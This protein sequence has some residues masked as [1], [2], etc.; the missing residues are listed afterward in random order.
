MWTLMA[1][2]SA[3]PICAVAQTPPSAALRAWGYVAH[4][5]P[6]GWRDAPL[7]TFERLLFF[8]AP[9]APSGRIEN[10]NGWPTQWGAL[11]SAAQVA[12]TPID[13]AVTLLDEK[14]FRSVFRSDA[15]MKTLQEDIVQL[16]QLDASAG[17]QLDVEVYEDI[18]DV[19]WE[20]Y[21]RWV[22]TLQTALS[23]LHPPRQLSIFFPMGGKRLL[24]GADTLVKIDRIVV[25]GYDAHWPDGANA[26]P[27]APM[28]GPYAMTWKNSVKLMDRLGV[29]REKTL[30]SFPLYG[31]EWRVAPT[32]T[33]SKALGKGIST[34]FAPL[35]GAARATFPISVQ[36]RVASSGAYVDALSGSSRYRFRDTASGQWIEG[37]FE[38]WWSLQMKLTFLQREHIGGIAFFALGYDRGLL[39]NALPHLASTQSAVRP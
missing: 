29:A 14:L 32:R 3:L 18:D 37:W 23:Q 2:C 7:A 22:Q 12:D 6:Q 19:L 15:R 16:A 28:N 20:R 1:L 5:V 11:I 24:Y 35:D 30:F 21:Q 38:D 17:I 31:Y 27:V 33:P 9:V 39:V 26:G 34:S 4:W 13:V 36:E 25:Q 8:D 10:T